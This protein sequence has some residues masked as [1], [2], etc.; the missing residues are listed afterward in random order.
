VAAFSLTSTIA[1][2]TKPSW[3]IVSGGDQIINPDL[4]RWY[5]ERA[6][7]HTTVIPGASPSIY[8]SH[9]KEVAAIITNAARHAKH[10]AAS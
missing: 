1:W 9:S 8:E 6:K 10:M 3:G 2:K 4:D 7:S 5:Y